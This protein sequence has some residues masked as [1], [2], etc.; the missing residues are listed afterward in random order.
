MK[1]YLALLTK[2]EFSSLY[3]FGFLR[4]SAIPFEMIENTVLA[5]SK[6]AELLNNSKYPIEFPQMHLFILFEKDIQEDNKAEQ[7]KIDDVLSL[8][9]LTSM[10]KTRYEESFGRSIYFYDPVFSEEYK[11]YVEGTYLKISMLDGIKALRS[12]LGLSNDVLDNEYI[13]EILEGM[14]FRQQGTKYFNIPGDKRKPISMLIAYDRNQSYSNEHIGYFYDIADLIYHLTDVNAMGDRD[15][16]IITDTVKDTLEHNAASKFKDIEDKLMNDPSGN[17]NKI[18]D[19]VRE[20][21]G[22]V[23]L[24]AFYLYFKEQIRKKDTFDDEVIKR[25]KRLN[26]EKV[27]DRLT[28]LLGSFFGYEKIYELYYKSLNLKIHRKAFDIDKFMPISAESTFP[29]PHVASS[30]VKNSEEQP[31]SSL[32]P[33][34]NVQG[35]ESSKN[36]DDIRDTQDDKL[37]SNLLAV[38]E[39]IS[40]SVNKKN[41]FSTLLDDPCF[42]SF[43]LNYVKSSD[44]LPENDENAKKLK[45]VLKDNQI[46]KFRKEYQNRFEK[47]VQSE[48]FPE[49]ELPPSS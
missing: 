15:D 46:A 12:I 26:D 42:L 41:N 40:K 25:L 10:A 39:K 14:K 45:E 37:K 23:C 21:F 43:M 48:I 38:F 13:E 19:V 3:K 33:A 16:S 11:C 35:T 20:T 1:T 17:G 27:F 49:E 8:I 47:P 36:A 18:C 9:P 5:H 4:L 7:L 22:D 2:D 29:E 34:E 6:A 28:Y 30:E 32:E 31:V 44:T 24:P